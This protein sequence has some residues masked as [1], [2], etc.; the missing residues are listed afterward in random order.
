MV[1]KQYLIYVGLLLV[2]NYFFSVGGDHLQLDCQTSNGFPGMVRSGDGYSRTVVVWASTLG[3][4][5]TPIMTKLFIDKVNDLFRLRK[6]TERYT[7]AALQALQQEMR[8]QSVIGRVQTL[9]NLNAFNKLVVRR[10]QSAA[11]CLDL[12]RLAG[13]VTKAP[14]KQ[15]GDKFLDGVRSKANKIDFGFVKFFDEIERE[16]EPDGEEGDYLAYTIGTVCV[17]TNPAEST[18]KK[19]KT[20]AKPAMT[21]TIL[22]T[23]RSPGDVS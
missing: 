11:A 9:I 4:D 7:I 3:G 2:I 23:K 20:D 15:V 19:R 6:I 1:I 17:P 22:K 21:K 8:L 18:K 14:S 10:S 12:V 5:I 16:V 13:A